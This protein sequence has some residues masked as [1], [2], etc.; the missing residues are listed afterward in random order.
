MNHHWHVNKYKLY[1]EFTLCS[2]Y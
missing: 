2:M 1:Q